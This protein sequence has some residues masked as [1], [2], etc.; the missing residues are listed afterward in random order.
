VNDDAALSTLLERLGYHRLGGMHR[1]VYRHA[2]RAE[3]LKLAL[4][5][6]PAEIQDARTSFRRALEISA[7]YAPLGLMPEVLEVGDDFRGT[8]YPWLRERYV[9]GDNLAR[10]Y[11]A[12]PA[13]WIGLL[14][15]E[16]AR[17]YRIIKAGPVLD[18]QAT[19]DDKLR[20]LSH[21]EGC[22]EE[23]AAVRR[24]G[25]YLRD[26]H[27]QGYQIHGDLHFGNML[28][29]QRANGERSLMLI[30]WEVSEV[31]PLGY[32]FAMLYTFLFDPTG[33]VQSDLVPAY[34]RR[35]PLRAMWEAIGPVLRQD[36]GVTFDEFVSAL[37]FRMG[38][39]RLQQIERALARGDSVM[40]KNYYRDLRAYTRGELLTALPYP[41][42]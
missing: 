42:A 10:M 36:L 33:Q 3:V 22:E 9:P 1:A 24:A 29:V 30:D 15:R 19:W 6:D 4:T 41:M 31:M 39:A 26:H 27:V 23:H 7:E 21:P 5:R 34:R 12:D 20:D 17:I 32:E 25:K 40:A 28:A 2:K 13:L 16:L 35:T 38:N 11:L 14:P 37:A 8:G 18:V